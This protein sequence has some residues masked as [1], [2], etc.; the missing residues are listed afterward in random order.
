MTLSIHQGLHILY[1]QLIA[2]VLRFMYIRF[3]VLI[4]LK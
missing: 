1:S 3:N 4:N 2:V